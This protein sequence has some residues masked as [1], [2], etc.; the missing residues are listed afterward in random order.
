MNELE[1]L[2]LRAVEAILP[3]AVSL[4]SGGVQSV[5]AML[6]KIMPAVVTAAPA[7]VDSVRNIITALRGSGV[8]KPDEIALVDAMA[9]D[10]EAALDAQAAIDGLV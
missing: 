8:L 4:T 7:V 10:M 1:I 3:S 5:L 2:A 6:A 9:N